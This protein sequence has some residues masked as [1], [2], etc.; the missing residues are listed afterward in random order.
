MGVVSLYKRVGMV[1]EMWICNES[2]WGDLPDG[3]LWQGMIPLGGVL[4][5][6]YIFFGMVYRFF[7]VGGI[8][9]KNKETNCW[10]LPPW[11]RERERKINLP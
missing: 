2:F 4:K 9:T 1:Y 7:I 11:D 10:G 6:R 5:I 3:A 8:F